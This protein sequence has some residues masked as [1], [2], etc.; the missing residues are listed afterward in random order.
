VPA[1]FEKET[2]MLTVHTE[3]ARIAAELR[4][5]TKGPAWHGPALLEVL[6]DVTPLQAVARP[7]PGAHTVWEIARHAA[8]WLDI[9]HER[10]DGQHRDVPDDEDWQ[11][12]DDTSPA[13]WQRLRARLGD[14]AERLAAR[15]ERFPDDALDAKLPGADASASS[16]YV[17]LHGIVQHVVYHAGQ[18]AV[19]KKGS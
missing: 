10:I 6:A 15:I 19:L 8:T 18:I 16:A 7:I 2:N 12:V 13:A 1:A 9:L 3:T 14:A 11:I 5:A 4:R 17:S